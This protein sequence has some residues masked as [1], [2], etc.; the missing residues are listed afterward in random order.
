M[1]HKSGDAFVAEAPK[2]VFAVFHG[3]AEPQSAV[4]VAYPG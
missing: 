1:Y 3:G 4:I 2:P